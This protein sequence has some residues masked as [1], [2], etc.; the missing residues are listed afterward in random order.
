MSGNI[1]VLN[2]SEY[3]YQADGGKCYF[4]LSEGKLGGKNKDIYIIGDA[5]LKHFYSAFDFESNQ[6]SLGINIHSQGMV[7]IINA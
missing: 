6:V 5:F 2:P 4:V 3:L 1:F 7:D